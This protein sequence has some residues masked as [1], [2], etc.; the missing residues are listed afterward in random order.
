MDGVGGWVG[1]SVVFV[2]LAFDVPFG[3]FAFDDS[4]VGSCA[5][6]GEELFAEEGESNSE[7]LFKVVRGKNRALG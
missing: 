1:L 5:S 4:G 7:E 6:V 3:V 2:V